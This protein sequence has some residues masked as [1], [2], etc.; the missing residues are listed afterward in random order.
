MTLTR[1]GFWRTEGVKGPSG[2]GLLGR[3]A[4]ERVGSLHVGLISPEAARVRLPLCQAGGVSPRGSGGSRGLLTPPALS[5]PLLTAAPPAGPSP[6][7]RE[8]PGAGACRQPW[9]SLQAQGAVYHGLLRPLAPPFS[10]RCA[11]GG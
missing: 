6:P 7:Q 8:E 5:H 11:G 3:V 9:P 1:H 2:S 10:P 4:V